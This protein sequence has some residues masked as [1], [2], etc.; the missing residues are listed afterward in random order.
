LTA[1]CQTYTSLET[2]VKRAIFPAVN[3]ETLENTS[4]EYGADGI[5]RMEKFAAVDAKA[6]I[7]V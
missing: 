6:K 5:T 4:A 1:E 7:V 3:N 2:T